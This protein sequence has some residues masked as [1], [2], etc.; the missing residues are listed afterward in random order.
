MTRAQ[1][2]LAQGKTTVQASDGNIMIKSTV[3][4]RPETRI[5]MILR[6]LSLINPVQYPP[7]DVTPVTEVKVSFG[8]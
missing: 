1:T 2:D 6:A 4:N 3:S 8:S 7:A 5:K